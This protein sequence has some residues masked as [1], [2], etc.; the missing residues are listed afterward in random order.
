MEN[1]K[2]VRYGNSILSKVASNVFWDTIDLSTPQK[3]IEKRNE[4]KSKLPEIKMRYG[5]T[6]DNNLYY[7]LLLW[8]SYFEWVPYDPYDDSSRKLELNDRLDFFKDRLVEQHKN[9]KEIIEL[10][11]ALYKKLKSNPLIDRKFSEQILSTLNDKKD[12]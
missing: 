5:N 8:P 3:I 4:L 12:D 10:Y 6:P 2:R 7:E 9:Y 1:S 11:C